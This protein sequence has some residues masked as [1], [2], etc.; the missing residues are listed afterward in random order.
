M[1]SVAQ[2]S[3]YTWPK[4]PQFRYNATGGLWDIRLIVPVGDVLICHCPIA[5]VLFFVFMVRV[6]EGS[7]LKPSTPPTHEHEADGGQWE[8][9]Q[10]K[11]ALSGVT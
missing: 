1:S 5:I 8:Q 6:T 9:G 3:Q 10:H 7:I 11:E 2:S 4:G